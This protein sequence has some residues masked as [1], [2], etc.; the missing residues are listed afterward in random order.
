MY[1][2]AVINAGMQKLLKGMCNNHVHVCS[3]CIQ[4]SSNCV[5]VCNNYVQVCSGTGLENLQ[6]SLMC[7]VLHK[8]ALVAAVQQAYVCLTAATSSDLSSR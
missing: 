7:Q 1:R 2:F 8:N 4:V 6:V 3:N 5:Q